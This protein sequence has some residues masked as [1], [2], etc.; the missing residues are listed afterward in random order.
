M[1]LFTAAAVAGRDHGVR[2]NIQ[3]G[4]E[5]LAFRLGDRE[6]GLDVLN[7]Q[8]IRSY[9]QPAR[10]ANAPCFVKGV[11]NLRG[12]IVPIV[13]LRI[14]LGCEGAEYNALTV[15]IVL[16]V[17]GRVLGAVADSVCDV[18]ELPPTAIEAAPD[19]ASQHGAS[20]ISGTV[21]VGDRRLTLLDAE[22]LL[23][24]PHLS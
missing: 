2:A 8:E 6:Y 20:V 11:V 22:A 3:W 17:K 14:R 24:D 21:C 12:T 9:E 18:L 16:N 4:G 10:L 19:V 1:N 23:A 5:F 15:V 7:V 13:D